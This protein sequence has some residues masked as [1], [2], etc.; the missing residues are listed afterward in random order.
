MKKQSLQGKKIL[1]LGG[2]NQHLKFV[3]H[4][5]N[6]CYKGNP[7]SPQSESAQPGECQ[8]IMLKTQIF[9]FGQNQNHFAD[10]IDI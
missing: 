10:T 7:Q 6:S 9:H 5:L 2:A 1:I 4:F 8:I 3:I